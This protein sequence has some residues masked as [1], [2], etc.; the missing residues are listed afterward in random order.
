MSI[1]KQDL[2]VL[3]FYFL[4]YSRISNLLFR[5]RR[6]PLTRI[7]IFHDIS[8]TITKKFEAHLLFLKKRTN[9]ISFDDFLSGKLSTEKINVIITFDD[10]YKS[11]VSHAI[12]LLEM[13]ELPAT[14]FVSSGFINL[15][16]NEE[17][18]FKKTKLFLKSPV[19]NDARCLNNEDI[20][21][22]S[23]KGFTIGGHTVHHCDLS[24][25]VDE[26]KIGFEIGQDKIALENIINKKIDYFSYPFGSYKNPQVNLSEILLKS[27]YKGAVTTVTG[28]NSI[29][30]DPY[31][32]CREITPAWMNRQVF[33]ARIFGNYDAVLFIKKILKQL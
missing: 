2:S 14:F 4:G 32:L 1:R 23:D 31:L 26:E 18:E 33:K 21:M 9:V 5:L 6:I 27:G 25:L 24:K 16:G 3:L 8:L 28:N 12:P 29:D 19:I 7:V 10:G 15:Q 17:A 22:I 30:S 20:K 13:L 11:W